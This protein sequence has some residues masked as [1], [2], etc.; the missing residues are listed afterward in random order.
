[1]AVSAYRAASIRLVVD[2]RQR[3]N[4]FGHYVGEI[5]LAEG[6]GDLG[7]SVLVDRC[8]PAF[9][10]FP[11]EPIHV[12]GPVDLYRAAHFTDGVLASYKSNMT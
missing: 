9:G 2:P 8:S 12:I 11:Y 5:L 10:G 6:I 1:V 4:R 7:T 3:R